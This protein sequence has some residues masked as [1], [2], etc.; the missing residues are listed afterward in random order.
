MLFS[1]I[2]GQTTIKEHLLRTVREDRVGHAQLFSGGEG[3]GALLLA[4]A[5]AQYLNCTQPG[6]HDACG[7]CP[8]CL[9]A[10]KLVHPDIHFVF[11]VVKTSGKIVS[12]DRIKEWREM[13]LRHKYF[14]AGDWFA[15]IGDGRKA[16]MIYADES[17]EI[18]R[19][20]SMKNFE[21]RYKVMIIWLPERMNLTG[22]NKLL[23]I[24]EEPPEATVFLLVSE[25]A[26]TLLPTI[27]SRTQQLRIPGI[28]AGVLTAALVKQ[29]GCDEGSARVAARLARGSYVQALK[30]LEAA[31]NAS[32]FF[33]AFALLMRSTYSRK[34]FDIMSWVEQTAPLSRDELKAFIDYAT[35]MLRE[36]YLY[37]FK[38]PEL[39]YLTPAEEDFVRRFSPFI[40]DKNVERMAAALQEAYAHIEQNGNARIVLFDTAIKIVPMFAA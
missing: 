40:T 14:G 24:L 36:S 30:Q 27:L 26:Q 11:P 7:R 6:D 23:K 10:A 34:I 4:L 37:N 8:S 9:K 2:A 35:G 5:Y 25:A 31:N 12:D 15:K 19:K 21:G 22:A 20:L 1:E 28:D 18:L 17:P 38:Q 39:V 3:S 29:T 16:G 13:V 32:A 33:E